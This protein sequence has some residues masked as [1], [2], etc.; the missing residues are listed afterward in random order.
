VARFLTTL[1]SLSDYPAE[2][3]DPLRTLIANLPTCLP[4]FIKLD[5]AAFAYTTGNYSIALCV[6]GVMQLVI[7]KNHTVLY[8]V[9]MAIKSDKSY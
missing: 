6:C 9:I 7:V 4:L 3:S 8:S 2:N 1:F 5:I